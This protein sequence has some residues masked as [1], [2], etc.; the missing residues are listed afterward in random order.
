MGIYVMSQ[1]WGAY[2]GNWKW[3]F[4]YFDNLGLTGEGFLYQVL[5]PAPESRN[6][7]NSLMAFKNDV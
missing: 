4:L 5:V 2:S 1:G 6:S 7:N 3:I